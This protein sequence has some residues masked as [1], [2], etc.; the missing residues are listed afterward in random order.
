M[1][2]QQ[3]FANET[4]IHTATG[5]AVAAG[6]FLLFEILLRMYKA[7]QDAAREVVVTETHSPILRA[8]LPTAR[9]IGMVLS[10]TFGGNKNTSMFHRMLVQ[11]R[12]R[13]A[14]AG[15]PEG[16]NAEEY[17]GFAVLQGLLWVFLMTMVW[18]L[19]EESAHFPLWMYVGAGF[20]LGWL[21]WGSWL[22]NKIRM[23]QSSI[24]KSLPFAL[25]ILTLS[26]EAG[27]DFTAALGRMAQKMRGT[28][29][30]REFT[31]M[32]HEIQ[33]GKTR[34]VAMRDFSDRVDMNETRTVVGSLIQAEELG[35]SL[36]PILRIQ[37]VQQRE[38][39]SQ[40][41]E[42]AA[43]K[44]P[45][46]MLFPLVLVLMAMMATIAAPIIISYL[47]MEG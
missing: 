15:S 39:R 28:P 30:G 6:S 32:L 41:A 38:R 35:A 9:A 29:L 8:F 10:G 25:D 22:T 2:L 26:M 47:Q 16:I 13:L 1:T 36:G 21:F 31:L 42:E 27:L 45:V 5:I 37:S 3:L 43:M 24:R 33:L 17:Y 46:K 44:A 11:T 4:L 40:R 34:T 23:R 7:H 14:T 12:R 18:T 20:M 19:L